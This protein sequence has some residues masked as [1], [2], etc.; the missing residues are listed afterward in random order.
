MWEF[1]FAVVKKKFSRKF[2]FAY[3]LENYFSRIAPIFRETAEHFFP[4]K[5]LPIKYFQIKTKA[6]FTTFRTS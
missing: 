5:F 4:R 1:F 2:S 3:G 6:K